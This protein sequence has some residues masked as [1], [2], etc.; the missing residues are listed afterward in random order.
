M[1]EQSDLGVRQDLVHPFVKAHKNHY[2]TGKFTDYGC[3][4]YSRV[5]AK[6]PASSR[7]DI[8]NSLRLNTHS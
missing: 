5:Q 8:Q 4:E 1:I 3:N 6:I 7:E 2:L